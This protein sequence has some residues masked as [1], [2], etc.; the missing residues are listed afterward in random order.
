VKAKDYAFLLLKFR[1]RSENEIYR[2]LKK[3]KFPEAVIKETI[4]FLK[5]K[6]FID[7][8]LFA[9]S[10]I[11]SRLKKSLGLRRI[12][13]EL[14]LKGIDVKLIEEQ[15]NKVKENY[16]EEETVADIARERSAK[17]KGVE[18][19]KARQRLYS[20]LLRRGFSSD[21]I[22]EAMDNLCKQTC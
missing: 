17:L 9:K 4:A 8:E 12:K 1:L 22:I 15:I 20:Y 2:R 7:D 18:P 19:K 14:N 16:S 13:S 6:R 5:E 21:A 10:W 11:D 3:K